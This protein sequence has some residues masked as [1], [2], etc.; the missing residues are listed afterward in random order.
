[1]KK[2]IEVKFDDVEWLYSPNW[3]YFDYGNC[4]RNLQVIMP[5]SRKGLKKK[6]PVIFYVTGAAWHKQEMYN[7]IPKLAE[8]A[9]KGVAIVSI[10]VR[11][12]DIAIFPAQVEDIK[13]AMEC[14]MRKISEFDLPFDM[15]EA[16]LMGHS[17]GGHLAM[18][19]VLYNASEMIKIP[20]VKGVILESASSDILICSNASLPAWMSVRPSA[21]LLGVDSIDGNEEMAYKASCTSLISEDIILPPV[22]M[23]HCI[24]DPVVSVE[25]SRT[26]YRKLDEKNHSVEYYEIKEWKEHGG[27]IYFSETVL[28]IIQDFIK[29][30]K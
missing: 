8:L 10:E 29:K 25:N 30:T 24:N 14:V 28:S 6:Y 9:K 5:Y 23:F 2:E 3:E 27:N 13:N 11:E 20:N 7:D 21:V 26:L 4:K 16:Y 17:S 1:M 22:L 15:N 12:S 19:A 18:M